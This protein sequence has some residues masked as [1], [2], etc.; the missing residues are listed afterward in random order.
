MGKKTRKHARQENRSARGHERG[1]KWKAS[2][3][4]DGGRVGV[5]RPLPPPP[6]PDSILTTSESGGRGRVAVMVEALVGA[7]V[8]SRIR[9]R[10]GEKDRRGEEQSLQSRPTH[11][12]AFGATSVELV[13]RASADA[14]LDRPIDL[15]SRFFLPSLCS[16]APVQHAPGSSRTFSSIAF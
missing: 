5:Y 10:K 4:R 15:R 14:I 6:L 3:L 7:A 11:T 8:T 13:S 16:L 1:K 12:R 2:S 9:E